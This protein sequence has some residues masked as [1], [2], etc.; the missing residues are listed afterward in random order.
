MYGSAVGGDDQAAVGH[1]QPARLAIHVAA[2]E[3]APVRA[4]DRRNA[5]VAA[6][7]QQIAG[8]RQA[9]RAR[10]FDHPAP[11]EPVAGAVDRLDHAHPRGIQ[12]VTGQHRT[13]AAAQRDDLASPAFAA[14]PH[15]ASQPVVAA[16]C[17][18]ARHLAGGQ[19]VK[20]DAVAVKQRRFAQ[21]H[22]LVRLPTAPRDHDEAIAQTGPGRTG[23]LLPPMQ[24]LPGLRIQHGRRAVA[25]GHDQH[26]AVAQQVA[27]RG[28]AAEGQAVMRIGQIKGVQSVLAPLD[29]PVRRVQRVVVDAFGRPHPRSRIDGPV[30]YQHPAAA[31]PTRD[32]PA[33]SRHHAVFRRGLKPPN[34]LASACVQTVHASV[35]TGK[36]T[37]GVGNLR[38]KA[39]RRGGGKRP[40]DRTVRGS[41]SIQRIVRRR[42]EVH[43][44][45]GD[46]RLN[47]L[48]EIQRMRRAP[49]FRPSGLRMWGA[50][51]DPGRRQRQR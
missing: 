4:V 30:Q 51:V 48:V 5:A 7:Q 3:H 44:A 50:A 24:K 21:P 9:V 42:T 34:L 28:R 45:A 32:H 1:G 47:G 22:F 12:P 18:I 27:L 39:D 2:P 43:D 31:R 36:E 35:V 16:P 41:Q 20:R 6:N 17:C 23:R 33:V 38:R 46:N 19:V 40:A 11:L 26:F 37:P 13:L 15:A 25:G 8:H 29:P 49:G 14:V 10:M